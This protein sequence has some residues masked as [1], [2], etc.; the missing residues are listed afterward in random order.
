MFCAVHDDI[1]LLLLA[2]PKKLLKF[3]RIY[4]LI[5]NSQAESLH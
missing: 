4:K 5:F 2:P 1:A 3:T